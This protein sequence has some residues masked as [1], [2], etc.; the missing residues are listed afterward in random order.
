[1]RQMSGAQGMRKRSTRRPPR[2]ERVFA[3]SCLM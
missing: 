3:S 2:S 1:L